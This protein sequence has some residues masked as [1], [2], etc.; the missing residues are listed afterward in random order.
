MPAGLLLLLYVNDLHHASKVLNPI[1]F[2]DERNLF[3]SHS[4]INV[5]FEKVN[6]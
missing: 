1:M 5:L 6:E 4:D 2:A 3:I